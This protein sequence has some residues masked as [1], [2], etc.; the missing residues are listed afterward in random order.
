MR[1]AIALAKNDEGKVY[2]GPFGHA[3]RFAIYEVGEGGRIDLLEVRENPYAAMEGGRKHELMRE[4]LK[5]VDLRVGA[6][7][8]HGG[9]MGAFPMADRLEVGPVSV[10]EA[11]EK[12][13]A[14]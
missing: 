4:L 11:L 14:R 9:S 13:R 10:A 5:D 8:G 7:F 2:P 1:V 12:V 3:P 6:R